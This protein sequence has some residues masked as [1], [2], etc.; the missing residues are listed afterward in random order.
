MHFAGA[1][2]I[3]KQMGAG[4][5]GGDGQSAGG[6]FTR[7]AAGCRLDRPLVERSRENHG[8][9]GFARNG[10]HVFRCSGNVVSGGVPIAARG[11]RLRGCKRARTD[12]EGLKEDPAI[13]FKHDVRSGFVVIRKAWNLAPREQPRRN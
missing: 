8:I 12:R 1:A 11:E 4:D 6:D 5:I 13:C 3:H 10:L 9:A 7:P 2:G